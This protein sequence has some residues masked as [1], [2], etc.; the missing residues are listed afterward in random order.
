MCDRFGLDA[1][2]MLEEKLAISAQ[3]YPV[4]KAKGKNLKYT[5]YQAPAASD[6]TP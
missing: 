3:R 2:Q 5:A 4:E 1:A 6:H